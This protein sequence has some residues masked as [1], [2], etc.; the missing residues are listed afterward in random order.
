VLLTFHG[1]SDFDALHSRRHD[2]QVQLYAFDILAPDGEDLRGARPAWHGCWRAGLT[3]SLSPIRAGR[4]RPGP[5]RSH[6]QHGA[7]RHGVEA[8]RSALSGRTVEGL[9]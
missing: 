2:D 6:M 7:G 1:I 9:D 8:G 3:A 5:V 4:D